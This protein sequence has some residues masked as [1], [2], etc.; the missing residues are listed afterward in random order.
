M[1]LDIPSG[2]RDGLVGFAG[3]ADALLSILDVDASSSPD[4]P[5]SPSREGGRRFIPGFPPPRP[6][7]CVGVSSESFLN[8]REFGRLTQTILIYKYLYHQKKMSRRRRLPSHGQ[9]DLVPV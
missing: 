2:P 5:R 1:S 8:S 3:P 7:H 6:H 9:L 4:P